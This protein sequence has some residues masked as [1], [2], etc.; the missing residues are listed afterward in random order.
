LNRENEIT[1]HNAPLGVDSAN[2]YKA[3]CLALYLQ[4]SVESVQS[5]V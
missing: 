1:D 3:G 2:G 4:S 5:A